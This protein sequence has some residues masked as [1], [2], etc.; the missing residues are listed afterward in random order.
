MYYVLLIFLQRCQLPIAMSLDARIRQSASSLNPVLLNL[1]GF[2][3]Q[4]QELELQFVDEA[5]TL[6]KK[7]ES[8]L[9]ETISVIQSELQKGTQIGY[10]FLQNAYRR[11]GEL[12][13][14]Q[15]MFQSACGK[16]C[17]MVRL[18]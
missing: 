6:P 11:R 5:T 17:Y 1:L 12:R 14:K 16:N 3:E 8:T 9:T 13:F 10:H 2:I 4:L 15:R 18:R 7:A